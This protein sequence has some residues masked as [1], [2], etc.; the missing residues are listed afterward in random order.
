VDRIEL[1]GLRVLGTHGVLESERAQPQ[2]FEVD[3]AVD[4]AVRAAGASDALADTV[5]YGA[6]VDAARRVV[7]EESYDLMERIAE[8][9]AEEVLA[10]DGRIAGVTVTVWK[11]RPPMAADLD[12]A[13]VTITRTRR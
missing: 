10:V 13:G 1:R 2:P 4:A 7:A 6:L 8:R 9:I 11:L 3:L 12:R 5:D